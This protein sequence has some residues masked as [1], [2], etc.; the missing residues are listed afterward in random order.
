MNAR[1]KAL[2]HLEDRVSEI[3]AANIIHSMEHGGQDFQHVRI[4][5]MY[6]SEINAFCAE[7]MKGKKVYISENGSIPWEIAQKILAAKNR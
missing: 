7:K 4:D 6:V 2:S 3:G 1:E 5:S